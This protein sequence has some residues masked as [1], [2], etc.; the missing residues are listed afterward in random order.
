[1]SSVTI[2]GVK[3]KY[4]AMDVLHGML[5]GFN[6]TAFRTQ[7]WQLLPGVANHVLGLEDGKKRFADHALAMSHATL[8]FS[9][10]TVVS[11]WFILGMDGYKGS[12]RRKMYLKGLGWLFHP[13]KGVY[14]Q[15]LPKI[16]KYY[17]PG[18]HPEDLP[19]VHNYQD[20]LKAFGESQN[21]IAAGEAMYAAAH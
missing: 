9:L 2:R 7:A 20:W 10:Y 13:K 19:T 6:Y 18:F 1:M 11:T 17:K 16:F 4:G 12:E 3:K 14:T 21:P 5:H 8:A 15:L